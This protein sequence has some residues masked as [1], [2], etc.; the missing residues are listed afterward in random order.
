MTASEV[1]IADCHSFPDEGVFFIENSERPNI[2][3]GRDEF[4]TPEELLDLVKGHFEDCGFSVLVN[5]P[6]SGCMIPIDYYRKNKHVHGIMI[7][8]NKR[9]YLDRGFEK[10]KG[11]GKIRRAI[12]DILKETRMY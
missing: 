9:L 1:V 7:E 8:V 4:H 3:L 5:Q 2:C 12:T 10:A 6:Y 11:F